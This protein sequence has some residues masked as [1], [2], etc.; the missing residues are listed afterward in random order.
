MMVA[1]VA[2]QR[3]PPVDTPAYGIALRQHQQAAE[4]A[5]YGEAV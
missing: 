4:W 2:W 5:S 1:W 3:W